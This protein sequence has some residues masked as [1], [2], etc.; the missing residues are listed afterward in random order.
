MDVPRLVAVALLASGD[1][2]LLLRRPDDG[3]LPGQWEFPGGKVEFGEHPWDA[4]RRELREE[5][6]LRVA[7]GALFGIYSHVY[8]LPGQRVHYV[9]VAYHCPIRRDRVRET[10]NRTWAAVRDLGRWPIVLGSRPILADL[11]RRRG[12]VT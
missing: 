6:A 3:P 4:L 11:Q 2:I 1:R 9:L 12:R 8:D 7:R 5:L 10:A